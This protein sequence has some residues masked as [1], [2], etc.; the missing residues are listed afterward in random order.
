MNPYFV[1]VTTKDASEAACIGRTV[2]SERLSACANILDSMKSFYW[3]KEALQEE[4]ESV[5]ILKT[6]DTRLPA[7]IERIKAL[8]SYECPCVVALPI[9]AGYSGFLQWIARETSV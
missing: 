1:Y 5:L 8:H 3:W 4:N 7:L 6:T 2:V 9:V